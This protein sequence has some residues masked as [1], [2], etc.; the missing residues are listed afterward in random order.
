MHRTTHRRVGSAGRLLVI[1]CYL[2]ILLAGSL[3]HDEVTCHAQARPDCEVCASGDDAVDVAIVDTPASTP[4][5]EA[6]SST[7]NDTPVHV[8]SLVSRRSLSDRSPP[9]V[10]V[11]R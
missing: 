2:A 10:P 3:L 7:L 1:A 8:R 4:V 9:A 11:L 6:A 5:L